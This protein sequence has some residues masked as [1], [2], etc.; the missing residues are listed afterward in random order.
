MVS[1]DFSAA[2]TPDG[3]LYAIGGENW[4]QTQGDVEEFDPWTS[5]WVVKGDILPP[6][7][8]H[9]ATYAAGAIFVV[10]GYVETLDA[11]PMCRHRGRIHATIEYRPGDGG[12]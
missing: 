7:G 9:G 12:G 1:N 11:P 8:L 3:K 5:S 6:R 10:G 2:S 4:G